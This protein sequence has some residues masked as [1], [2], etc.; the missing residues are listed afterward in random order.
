MVPSRYKVVATLP[1][2]AATVAPAATPDCSADAASLSCR[3]T[4]VLHWLEATA[5]ILTI[6]LIAVIG[7]AIHF[8]RKNRLGRKGGP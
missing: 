7:V 4:G 3:L 5:F 6:V 8:F 2:L 1:L